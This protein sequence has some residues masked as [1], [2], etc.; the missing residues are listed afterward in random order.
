[1]APPCQVGVF[2]LQGPAGLC[3][4]QILT[5]APAAPC[6]SEGAKAEQEGGK[7]LPWHR[8]HRLGV[9]GCPLCWR[10]TG[11]ARPWFFLC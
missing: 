1:M 6:C 9:S 2:V 4:P 11:T 3:A 7:M 10:G 8:R 5:A